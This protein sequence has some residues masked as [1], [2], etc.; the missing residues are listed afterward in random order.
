ME[1]RISDTVRRVHSALKN[2]G[3]RPGQPTGLPHE[4]TFW[5][6]IQEMI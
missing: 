4:V 5:V 1:N 2:G 6:I 3:H